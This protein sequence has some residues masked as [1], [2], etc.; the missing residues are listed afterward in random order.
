M[1]TLF[2]DINNC[3]NLLNCL[4]F[5][6]HKVLELIVCYYVMTVC[7]AF[8]EG[9]GML[10][11]V[12]L[13]SG[14]SLVN[15]V[16]NL[17]IPF[18]D[19]LETFIAHA[20]LS[21]SILFVASIF[22]LSIL[23]KV[24]LIFFDGIVSAVLRRKI[25]EAI[26]S[27]YLVSDWAHVRDFQVGNVVGINTYEAIVVAKYLT[28]MLSVGFHFLGAIV[29]GYLALVTS[30]NISL[31]LG[32]IAL[33][34][35]ILMQI[36]SARQANL[37]KETAILRNQFSADIADRYNGLLQILL[38]GN[39]SH[40]IKAG[41]QNQEALT[42]IE[43]KI[44]YYQALLGS[45]SNLLLFAVLLGLAIWISFFGF[46]SV[47]EF[48]IIA[49]VG[50]LGIKV[51]G[52]LQ[53]L[54]AAIGHVSRLSGSFPPLFSALSIPSR[55]LTA[56]IDERIIGVNLRDV[57]FGYDDNKVLQGI[58]IVLRRGVPFLL[59]GRSGR[60]KT[61]LANLIA[62]LYVPTSG[63]VEYISESEKLYDSRTFHARIGF[64]TQDIYLFKGSLRSNLVV[65]KDCSEARI[66]KVLELVDAAQFV[67]D[68]GGLDAQR[69]EA[70][71]ALSGG[72]RRRLG[73]ARALL[74]SADVLIFDEI[75]AGL[76]EI[77]RVAILSLIESLSRQYLIVMISHED[78]SISGTVK[79]ML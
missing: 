16:A 37:S 72:Q 15:T 27:H 65:E 46:Q 22:G 3:R 50:V 21:D 63:S 47:P 43:I 18:K 68:L 70:G 74:S 51:A 48:A 35:A 62:G 49:T 36:T 76:D 78:V 60:G 25:Q 20:E 10:L 40:H 66:W 19:T 2:R 24:G 14:G 29:M 69:V 77:N 9:L 41:L 67:Y 5:S 44:S 30:V 12:S 64:V 39:A 28:S 61:T 79:Y 4:R 7:S 31:V 34:L 11:L 59:S 32:G 53:C 57:T 42:R 6:R 23:F 33:P 17:P 52:Q 71:R 13:F 26:F 1:L 73:I 54:I 75:T 8:L 58:N 56:P 38:D 55:R 45:F